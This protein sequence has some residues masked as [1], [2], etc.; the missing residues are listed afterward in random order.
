MIWDLP[1]HIQERI[2]IIDP[3]I[4]PYLRRTDISLSELSVW[5]SHIN[6]D[7]VDVL[8]LPYHEE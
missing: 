6:F 4:S 8:L 1:S 3:L 5:F 7:A 2:E